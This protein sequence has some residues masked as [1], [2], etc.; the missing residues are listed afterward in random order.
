MLNRK[1]KYCGAKVGLLH[2]SICPRYYGMVLGSQDTEAADSME[3]QFEQRLTD[4]D[5]RLLTDMKIGLE[6]S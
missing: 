2:S 3:K 4:E 5:R 6:K 1:C